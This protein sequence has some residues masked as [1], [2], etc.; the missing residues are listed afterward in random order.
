[1]KLSALMPTYNQGRF[2]AQAL[3]SVL[4]QRVNFEYEIIVG[5]DCSTDS[6]REILMDFHHRHPEKIIPLLRERN[7]GVQNFPDMVA[8]CRGE[9][10][11]ILEGDDY[12]TR[13]DKLQMQVHF[14]DTHLDHSVCYTRALFVEEG[15]QGHSEVQP[16]ISA[17][18]YSI[19]DL[20]A[21]NPV[22]TCTVMYR[23]SSVGPLPDWTL[24][25]KMGDWPL[26]VLVAR[27]GKVRLLDEV[28]ST[29]CIHPGGIWPSLSP[30]DQKLAIVEMLKTMEMH[31]DSQYKNH[32]CGALAHRYLE[33]ANGA[34]FNGSRMGNARYQLRAQ[35]SLTSSAE[36][37]CRRPRRLYSYR[38]W[39]QDFLEGKH[40]Y[41]RLMVH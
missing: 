13:D 20:F 14:L 4:A 28:T 39:L 37:L 33:L 8:R 5:E 10:V 40:S 34:R 35:R 27:S 38:L 26:H 2:L 1:M 30:Q 15:A 12:W 18:S 21:I 7:L 41:T 16:Q 22:V 29:Y 36:P 31:L 24:G 11:A 6:T 23:W 19:T 25:L 9:Y 17:G 32:I 3:S